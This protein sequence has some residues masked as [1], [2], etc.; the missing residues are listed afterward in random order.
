MTPDS[1]KRQLTAET[2]AVLSKHHQGCNESFPPPFF[3]EIFIQLK[4]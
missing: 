3:F 4:Y 1:K 2:S